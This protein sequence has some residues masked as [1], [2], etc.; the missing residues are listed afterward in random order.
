ME[1]TTFATELLHEVRAQAKRWFIA[2]CVMVGLEVGTI[3]G[4]M[5]YISLPVETETVEQYTD[6]DANSQIGI[7]DNYGGIS[8][9][10]KE[11]TGDTVE[12]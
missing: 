10:D 8:E 9:S 11:K 2:F 7:G 6:G 3:A 4:F 5:W 12:K 1:N